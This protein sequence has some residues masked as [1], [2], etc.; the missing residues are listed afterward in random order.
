MDYCCVGRN[1]NDSVFSEGMLL[2]VKILMKMVNYF[3]LGDIIQESLDEFNVSLCEFV[4]VMEIVFLT[5]SRLL[6]GKVVLT[7]EMA[8]KFFVVIGSSL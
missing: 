8:I 1:N 7:L 6:I 2:R 5:V 3:R 4:R